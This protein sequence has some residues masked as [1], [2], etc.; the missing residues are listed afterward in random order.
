MRLPLVAGG[1]GFFAGACAAVVLWGMQGLSGLIWPERPSPLYIFVLIMIGGA[2]IAVLRHWYEGES[3][4]GQLAEARSPETGRW[5][6]TMILAAM[7][8]VAIAFGGA[9]GPEAGI[10]AVVAEMSLVISAILARNH[11]EA[12]MI[13]EVGASGALSG[14]YGSPPAG[15]AIAQEP[16]ETPKWQ[17]FLAAVAGLIGFILVGQRILPGGGMRVHLPAYAATGDVN[18]IV[19]ALAPGVLGAAVGLV[20]LLI[21]PRVQSMIGRFGRPTTQTIIGTTLFAALAATFPIIR[22]SGHH[23]LEQLLHWSDGVALWMLIGVALLKIAAMALCLGSGW[24]GGSCFPLLFA[25]AAVGLV[26]LPLIPGT[27]ATVALVAAMTAAVTAGMGKPLAAMLIAVFLI[28]PILPGPLCVG[29]LIG[30]AFSTFAPKPE[31]H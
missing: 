25:G 20:F 12:R 7:A 2:L 29:A 16:L 17:L 6:N 18:D 27:P 26:V 11:A 5:R 13:G 30:W 23:E 9:I 4:A 8:V 10:L 31:L 19:W 21:L 24:R 1:Y 14:L 3:L 15:A 28:G 22:F